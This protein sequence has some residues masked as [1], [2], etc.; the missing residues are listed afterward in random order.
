MGKEID[1]LKS[2]KKTANLTFTLLDVANLLDD[3]ENGKH[4]TK[5]VCVMVVITFSFIKLRFTIG[6]FLLFSLFFICAI[7]KN[8]SSSNLVGNFCNTKE[9]SK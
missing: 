9:K 7:K 6:F 4:S 5:R 3:L 8:V 2:H 1:Q